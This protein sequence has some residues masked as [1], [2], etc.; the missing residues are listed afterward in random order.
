MFKRLSRHFV[1]STSDF[2]TK[3]QRAIELIRA[4]VPECCRGHF[5]IAADA[6]TETTVTAR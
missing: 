2:L 6:A 3:A 1:S 5:L 4:E